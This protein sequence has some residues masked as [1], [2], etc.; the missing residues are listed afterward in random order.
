MTVMI[1]AIVDFAE[2]EGQLQVERQKVDVASHD[3]SVR[4][5]V[6]MLEEGELSISPEYQR[7]YRWQED[8]SST[9]VE[10]VFLGLPIP[11]IFVATNAEFQWEVVDGLQRLSTLLLFIASRPEHLALVNRKAPLK[12]QKL[13]KLSQLN[14]VGY[15]DLPVGLQRY[16]GRQPL[17]VISLTDKSNRSVRFDLFERLNAGAISL[18]PQEVR[19]CIYGGPFND[20]VEQMARNPN[21]ERLLKLQELK[22]NDGTAAEEV[23][24]FFAYKNRRQEFDGRVK[25]FL[26]E[27]SA[28][29]MKAFHYDEEQEVFEKTFAFLLSVTGGPFLRNT[30]AVTPLVQLEACAVAIAE[31]LEAGSEPVTPGDGWIE[32]PELVDAS[33]GGS[34]TRSKLTRRL[35]RAKEIF[36]GE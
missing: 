20:F 30:T 13:Q 33:T 10:S 17:Q 4:E 1:P 27:Y 16:F 19:A 22:Q 3:F 28:E 26:N 23:L 29:A 36:S 25:T 21:F 15:A 5:L 7:K 34:N 24:K 18:S 9:F 31:I 8:V 2:L 14:G 12:L 32:D 6:R 11:P 35:K